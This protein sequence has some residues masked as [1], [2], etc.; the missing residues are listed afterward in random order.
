MSPVLLCSFLDSKLQKSQAVHSGP[1][2]RHG[3]G[4]VVLCIEVA[5]STKKKVKP[6][7]KNG[8]KRRRNVLKR[9]QMRRG[10]SAKHAKATE[11]P[12]R[13]HRKLAHD[14]LFYHQLD[15]VVADGYTS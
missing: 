4:G 5:A 11:M 13:Q 8:P 10:E 15:C 2:E 6:D 7:M 9:L 12:L 14:D 3:G 1:K